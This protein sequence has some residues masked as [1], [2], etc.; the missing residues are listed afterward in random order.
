M[1]DVVPFHT[2]RARRRALAAA[3]EG[4]AQILFFLGVRYQRDEDGSDTRPGASAGGP[5]RRSG[6]K[7]R[8]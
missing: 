6:R 3:P 4:P 8:A 7:K 5:T 1:G 2:Q